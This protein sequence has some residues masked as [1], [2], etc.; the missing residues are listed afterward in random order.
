VRFDSGAESA[1]G[2]SKISPES[3]DSV[4]VVRNEVLSPLAVAFPLQH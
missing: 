3:R 4:R 1:R 2:Q